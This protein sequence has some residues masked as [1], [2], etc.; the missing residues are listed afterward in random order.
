VTH[1]DHKES[2][3]APWAECVFMDGYLV[4][5]CASCHWVALVTA[6]IS[7]VTLYA[8][9]TTKKG[10]DDDIDNDDRKESDDEKNNDDNNAH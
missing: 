2:G 4:G 3:K 1:H 5:P 9:S 10:V 6:V 8:M 7:L